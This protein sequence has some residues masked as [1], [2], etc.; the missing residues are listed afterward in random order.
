[1]DTTL[2]KSSDSIRSMIYCWKNSVSLPS[3][4]SLS[5]GYFSTYFLSW[6]ASKWT[7]CLVL[8]SWTGTSTTFSLKSMMWAMPFTVE[9]SR[10]WP[11]NN[12]KRLLSYSKRIPWAR[13]LSNW[14]V[15]SPAKVVSWLLSLVNLSSKTLYSWA[16][17]RIFSISER[18]MLGLLTDL[19]ADF[20]RTISSSSSFSRFPALLSLSSRF[21]IFFS[22]SMI[23]FSFS[24]RIPV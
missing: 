2:S 16:P 17:I 14:P 19:I 9:I 12:S 24:L 15:I 4:S 11:F 10:P 5:L 13:S 3:H 7:K 20:R 23:W 18:V 6:T 22:S 1:M 21:W 8:A